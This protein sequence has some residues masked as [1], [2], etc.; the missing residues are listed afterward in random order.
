MILRSLATSTVS[1]SP[2]LLAISLPVLRFLAYSNSRMFNPDHNPLL[3]Y[4][5]NKSLYEQFCAGQDANEVAETVARV[6]DI[7][8]TGAIL[9]YARESPTE[10]PKDKLQDEP[11]EKANKDISEWLENS[12]QTVRL[13]R[14][15]DFVALKLTGAGSLAHEQLK[16]GSL[17]GPYF[18]ESINRICQ[19]ARDNGVR[20]LI[21]GEQDELQ[22]TIDDWTLQLAARYN[23]IAGK[24]IVFGTYQAYKKTM[25]EVLVSHLEEAR[26]QGFTL[27]VKLVRGAYLHSDPPGRLQDSKPDTDACYD[28]AAASVLTREWNETLRGSGPYPEA[29][30]MF[31]THNATSVRKAYAIHTEGRARS[32]ILFAQ[33]QGMADEISCELVE[34]NS[35]QSPEEPAAPVQS[36]LPVYKYMAWGTTGECMKYLLRRAEENRD[37]VTRTREDRDAMWAE[38]VRRVKGRFRAAE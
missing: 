34:M 33:L 38:L 26:R 37:A 19:F 12:L 16:N 29:S 3:R 27:G 22:N 5:L 15:G 7:G 6:K 1:S 11:E 31:A 8:F 35:D 21:D 23:I 14:A 30:I 36:Y 18:T 10:I 25:P 28:A 2:K 17:P 24:A 32:E 20:V 13:A 9:A 4:V